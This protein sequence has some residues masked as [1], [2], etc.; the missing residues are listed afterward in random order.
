MSVAAVL[1]RLRLQHL[2]ATFEEEELTEVS[3]LRSMGPL[4]S[5][6]LAELGLDAATR[7]KLCR[8]LLHDES[9]GESV[10]IAVV[11]TAR[12]TPTSVKPD[13][14]RPPAKARAPA[15]AVN[16]R[17]RTSST[18]SSLTEDPAVAREAERRRLEQMR[19]L[20]DSTPG[21]KVFQ[22]GDKLPGQEEREELE[23]AWQRGEFDPCD[24]LVVSGLRLRRGKGCAADAAT[25]RRPGALDDVI[26]LLRGST[27]RDERCGPFFAPRGQEAEL[28]ARPLSRWQLA[29]SNPRLDDHWR[30]CVRAMSRGDTCRFTCAA[31]R[32]QGWLQA[33]AD[34]CEP[35]TGCGDE[36]AAAAVTRR[37]EPSG[38]AMVVE[39]TLEAWA[40]VTDVSPKQNQTLLKRVLVPPTAAPPAGSKEHLQAMLRV[41]GENNRT[42]RGASGG[43]D[44]LAAVRLPRPPDRVGLRYTLRRVGGGVAG[45]AVAEGA[46]GAEGR[47]GAEGAA[48]ADS[49][50]SEAVAEL[51]LGADSSDCW[52]VLE[53]C[54]SSLQEG[55]RALFTFPTSGEVRLGCELCDC[56]PDAEGGAHARAEL[57]LELTWLLKQSDISPHRDGSLLKCKLHLGQGFWRP[58]HPYTVTVTAAAWKGGGCATYSSSAPA[59][60]RPYTFELFGGAGCAPLHAFVS[61]MAVGEVAVMTASRER[62]LAWPG[63]GPLSVSLPPADADGNLVLWLRLDS[64]RRVEEFEADSIAPVRKTTLNED[65]AAWLEE[66]RPPQPRHSHAPSTHKRS[67]AN[68]WRPR[69]GGCDSHAVTRSFRPLTPRGRCA[70]AGVATNVAAGEAPGFGERRGQWRC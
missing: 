43:G 10:G 13:P 33:L 64:F 40:T 67:A 21:V 32:A 50:G 47:G 17:E 53:C 51:T 3:L 23:G 46:G 35:A 31:R 54:V 2:Y 37:L 15:A 42:E 24:D 27:R 20:V 14:V 22:E 62:L 55:E 29:L 25:G 41:A 39:L 49:C 69:C 44:G 26:I 68:T 45:A 48:G 59:A 30:N 65:D 6:N 1:G 70:T 7:D 60:A 5:H 19:A 38:K 66:A 4:L 52:A 57:D 16:V 63:D 9:P 36:A 18:K 11:P 12:T 28:A 34:C 58:S 56:A 61:T 8:A